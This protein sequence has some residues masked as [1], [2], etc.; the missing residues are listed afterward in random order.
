MLLPEEVEAQE[1]EFLDRYGNA[2]TIDLNEAISWRKPYEQRWIEAETQLRTGR[3]TVIAGT[4]EQGGFSNTSVPSHQ[5]ATDNITKPITRTIVARISNMLF[6]TDETQF[7]IE[8]SP[9]STADQFAAKPVPEQGIDLVTIADEAA[10]AMENLV[11][12][13]LAEASFATAGRVAIKDGAEV[14]TGVL[15]GPFPKMIRER[16]GRVQQLDDGST[17][18]MFEYR[19]KIAP[20]VVRLDFRRFY[21][22]PCRTI[23]ECEGVFVLDLMTAK[24]LEMLKSDPTFSAPQIDMVLDDKAGPKHSPLFDSPV[25]S[26]SGGVALTVKG[27]YPVWTYYGSIKKKAV[28]ILGRDPMDPPEDCRESDTVDGEVHFCQGVTIKAVLREDSE[29]LPFHVYNYIDDPESIFG[30]GSPHELT[31]DQ[32]DV[33]LAWEAMKLNARASA[34]PITG[35]SAKYLSGEGGSISW[36]PT[37]PIQFDG[38]DIRKAIQITTIPSTIGDISQ[39]YDRAKANANAHSMVPSMDEG[40]PADVRMGASMFAML[41]IEQNIVTASAA[42]KWDDRVTKP[43]IE[44]F[45]DFNLAYSEDDTVKGA[46]DVVPKAASHLLTKD[47]QAQQAMQILTLADNPAN[48]PF[49][50]R[51]DLVK[52]VVSRSNLMTDQV[53]VS[54]AEA[55]EAQQAQ[56]QQPNPEMLKLEMQKSIEEMKANNS[57]QIAQI[58]AQ[59]EQLASQMTLE[60]ASI[61]A[62]S[63]ETLTAQE[64]DSR[65]RIASLTNESKQF[66]ETLKDQRERAKDASKTALK[67]EEIAQKES[68]L[69]AE[70]ELESPDVRL[71]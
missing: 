63:D 1:K 47:I 58:K 37:K 19:E 53:M 49:F 71:A 25:M 24:Q 66:A 51:Y 34:M 12:D 16:I 70:I 15:Y 68:K 18:M 21:P 26:Q 60:A 20:S 35:I 42:T 31:D 27:K 57:L 7:D 9:R 3:T 54:K 64:L 46:F 30:F 14:G 44:A 2:L 50:K 69:A 10:E 62:A 32:Y 67:A 11:K 61:K 39:I 17:I 4:K 65:A 22:R 59:S 13:Q 23:I 29:R 55:E 41:K 28:Q 40:M 45:I 36:P 56:A 43:L 38:D 5:K 33:S 8:P 48:A 6:G 52:M